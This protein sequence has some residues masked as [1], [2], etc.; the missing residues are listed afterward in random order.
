M[1]LTRN[2]VLEILIGIIGKDS[3]NLIEELLK[4]DNISEFDLAAKTKKDIKVVRR[5]LYLLYNHNLVSFNRKKD[6]QKGWYIYYWT[7]L[8][9][10][11][12]FSYFKM[13]RDL[14][15]GLTVRL[16]EEEKELFF[17]CPNNCARLNFDQATVFEFHCPE[18][19]EL[20]NQD[21]REEKVAFLKKKMAETEEELNKLQEQ[22]KVR[23][24]AIKTKKGK[25]A[26]NKKESVKKKIVKKTIKKKAVNKKTVEKEVVKKAMKKKIII[27]KK[28]KIT[29]KEASIK[30]KTTKINS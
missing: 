5:M 10:S 17:V 12:R 18:C 27:S 7:L 23:K 6:K 20:I 29:R 3:A 19:G 11:I 15:A 14:L 26:V 28:E 9:E 1:R 21:S 4:K 13:K 25:V 22:R 30:K 2:K 16:E 24:K 8:P